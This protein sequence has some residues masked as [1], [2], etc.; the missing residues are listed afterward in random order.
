MKKPIVFVPGRYYVS[1]STSGTYCELNCP[2]CKGK[3]LSGMDDVTDP[4]MLR[5]V[6]ELHYA[7]GARGFLLSGGFN[8][9]GYIMISEEHLNTVKEFKR[10]H[11]DVVISIHSG[12]MPK[13]L[14][15]KV[16]S[17]DVDFIDFEVPPSNKYLKYLK[18]LRRHSVSD[19]LEFVEEAIKYSRDFIVPH[20]VL[21]SAGST[22]NDELRVIRELGDLKLRLIVTLIEIRGPQGVGNS[23]FDVDRI[24]EVLRYSKKFFTEVALGC[25]RPVAFKIKYDETVVQEGLVDR[26]VNPRKSIIFKY[27]LPVVRACCSIKKEYFKLFPVE[28]KEVKLI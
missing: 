8:K 11:D 16:W 23:V 5:K 13:E 20:I 10:L 14:L 1:L 6:L 2:Y 27:N 24:R 12:L 19:Y 17:T 9:E 7:R 3:Y 18:N 15:N 28:I 25:M 22:I 21:H 4:R 26:L